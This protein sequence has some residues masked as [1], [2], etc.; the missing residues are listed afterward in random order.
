M[1]RR[2][3]KGQFEPRKKKPVYVLAPKMKTVRI[4][5][6]TEILVSADIPDEEARRR[7]LKRLD[8]R[9]NFTP[10]VLQE[11]KKELIEEE[12][13]NGEEIPVGS[14]EEMETAMAEMDEGE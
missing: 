3:P 8:K 14:L 2:L 11:V 12:K 9:N 13:L 6:R 10:S 5:A 7:F 1:K 4:D